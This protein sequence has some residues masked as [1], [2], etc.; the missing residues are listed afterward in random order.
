MV[1][2]FL[3][4]FLLALFSVTSNAQGPKGTLTFLQPGDDYTIR[5]SGD[6]DLFTKSKSSVAY[7]QTSDGQRIP[8]TTSIKH[9]VTTF[10]VIELGPSQWTLLEHPAVLTEAGV[11]NRKLASAAKL[12][13]ATIEKLEETEEGQKRLEKLRQFSEESVETSRTWVNLSHAIAISPL[14]ETD[15]QPRLSFDISV[16]RAEA[17]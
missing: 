11:W 5:F 12:V 15:S 9:T 6:V 13:P 16:S 8:V 1:I 3:A 10:R 2:R 17:K 14:P 7:G 4:L